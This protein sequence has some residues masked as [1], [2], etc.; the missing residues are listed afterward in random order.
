MRNIVKPRTSTKNAEVR[1]FYTLVSILLKNIWLY[2]QKKHFTIVKRGPQV[3]DE[4]KF[5]FNM[6]I[7]LIEEWLRK[8][9]KVRLMV[10]CLQ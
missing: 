6:F 7:L 3:V 5:R 10:E 4:D 1:Y 8:K 9:L 2:L